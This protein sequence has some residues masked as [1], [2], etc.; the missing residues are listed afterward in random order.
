M[1]LRN[2]CAEIALNDLTLFLKAGGE[3][4]IYDGT[5]TTRQRRLNVNTQLQQI[6]QHQKQNYSLVWLEILCDDEELVNTNIIRAKLNNPDFI[7]K[8]QDQAI[9]EFKIRIQNYLKVYQQVEENE[10]P[11]IKIIKYFNLGKKILI[12]NVDQSFI[13]KKVVGFIL[14]MNLKLTPIYLVQSDSHLNSDSQIDEKEKENH[15]VYF[16]L[17]KMYFKKEMKE[18]DQFINLFEMFVQINNL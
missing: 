17:V 3:V 2:K 4:G 11:G 13:Q 14:N 5:N 8:E 16:D 12:R 1:Q 7:D 9:G 6:I 18:D 10:Y 15:S